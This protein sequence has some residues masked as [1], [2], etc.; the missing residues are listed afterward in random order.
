MH[1]IRRLY[2]YLIALISV[3]TVIWGSIYLARTMVKTGVVISQTSDM[4]GG[5]SLVLVG[6]PIFLLHWLV[7]QRD[8][9][10]DEEERTARVRAFFLYAVRLSTL[11]AI[12]QS[13]LA[14]IN[15]LVLQLVQLSPVEAW[16]G[17][18]DTLADNLIIILIN[19][20]ALVYFETILRADWKKGQTNPAFSETRRLFRYLWM[21]YTLGI[22]VVGVQQI[23][24]ALFS[25]VAHLAVAGEINRRA[26]VGLDLDLYPASVR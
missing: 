24:F 2:F 17:G 9:A 19:G 12:V 26:A 1:I 16:I 10:H 22:T 3:E 15:R 21:L 13:E 18:S 23:F 11:V 14:I 7:A 5:F 20:V 25:S 4:A 8:A 6:L